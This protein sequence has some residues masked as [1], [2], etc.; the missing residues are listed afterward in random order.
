MEVT[1]KVSMLGIIQGHI[2]EVIRKI[3][4]AYPTHYRVKDSKGVLR[5]ININKFERGSAN[6]E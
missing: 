1:A 4:V 6:D 3:P 2:Y 5:T